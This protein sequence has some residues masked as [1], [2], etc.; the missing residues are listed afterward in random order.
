MTN[1]GSQAMIQRLA[2]SSCAGTWGK[3]AFGASQMGFGVLDMWLGLA[4]ATTVA[5][6]AAAIAYRVLRIAPEK[7]LVIAIIAMP[8]PARVDVP[9]RAWLI[10][11]IIGLAMHG[12]RALWQGGAEPWRK[13]TPARTSRPVGRS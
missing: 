13:A 3:V 11:M 6:L 4:C 2:V 12:P 1:L 5:M 10:G 9:L 7:A 8:L